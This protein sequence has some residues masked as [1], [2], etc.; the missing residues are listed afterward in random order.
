MK[1]SRVLQKSLQPTGQPL[2]LAPHN[3]G[4]SLWCWC[5]K[6]ASCCPSTVLCP[7]YG[8]QLRSNTE[9]LPFGGEVGAASCGETNSVLWHSFCL[10]LYL[11]LFRTDIGHNSSCSCAE[12]APSTHTAA[13][14]QKCESQ[15]LWHHLHS[16][17]RA[18]Y[19]VRGNGGGTKIQEIVKN[20]TAR[21]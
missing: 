12:A 7:G 17:I 8:Q 20:K 3:P 5:R 11:S 13:G 2:S 6:P 19:N 16:A 10:S 1:D 15:H 14:A 18:M 21:R 9:P 4:R